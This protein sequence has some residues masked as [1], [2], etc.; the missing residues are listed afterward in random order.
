LRELLGD[1]AAETPAPGGGSAAAWAT[2]LAA[3]LTEMAAAFAGDGSAARARALR[4]QALEL[5]ERELTAYAPVLEA[6]R[7]PKDDPTRTER[8]QGALSDAANSPL[9]IARVAAE[10]ADIATGLAATGNRSLEGDANTGAELARAACRAAARL[11][12]IN[13]TARPNDPRAAEA[14]QL[15]TSS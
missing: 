3:A 13:L 5:A 9:E 12:E 6:S 11:V 8:L 2:A 15:A 7:L 1:L 14:K 4:S 10:V